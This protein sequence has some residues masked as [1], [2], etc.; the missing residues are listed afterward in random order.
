MA[1]ECV[2]ITIDVPVAAA[3]AGAGA[4]ARQL[5]VLDAVRREQMDWRAAASALGM[6]LSAFLDLAKEHGVPVL[7]YALEDWSVSSHCPI[8][9]RV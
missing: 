5:L 3:G 9:R 8:P 2:E 4:R 7:R 6:S 1:T